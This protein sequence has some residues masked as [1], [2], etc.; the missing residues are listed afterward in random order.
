MR[1]RGG[2]SAGWLGLQV[3][4]LSGWC[5][6]GRGQLGAKR[7]KA[8]PGGLVNPDRVTANHDPAA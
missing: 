7:P 4:W 5:G 6:V 1:L 3:P 8:A 2:V